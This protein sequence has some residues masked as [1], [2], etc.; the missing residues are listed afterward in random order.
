MCPLPSIR[1]KTDLTSLRSILSR[2]GPRAETR[3]ETPAQTRVAAPADPHHWPSGHGQL[4]PLLSL[5][6]LFVIWSNSFHS[7]AWLM[8]SMSAFDLVIARFAPVGVFSIVWCLLHEPKHNWQLLRQEPVRIV[9][10]GILIVPVYNFFLNWGQEE[11]PAGTASLL[12]AM[13]PLFTYLIALAIRQEHHR[14]RKTVGLLLSFSGVYFLL[15]SE[16]RAFG[17][18][19]GLRALSVLAA[20]FS[21]AIATVVARPV[22][23]RENP[24]RMTY[25]SLAVGSALFLAA[26]P[27][28]HS[29]RRAIGAFTMKD[30]FALT[31]LSLL[32]TIVGFG[33][34]YSTLRK[35]PAS[36]VAAFV[37]LNPPLTIAFGP[38]WG[39]GGPSGPLVLF[40]A[41]IL[42][43]IIL[44]TWKIPDRLTHGP[45]T[46][47]DSI[48]SSIGNRD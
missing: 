45:A 42:A 38:L 8:R 25:L 22:V 37:L 12:I 7:I 24:I 28:D 47:L 26:F 48:R 5:F 21:W 34:W 17:P 18:G 9:A 29:L 3:A 19:Y 39:S 36:S 11:V 35:L 20:P 14:I 40:G 23:V 4:V 1:I 41:W 2:K 15:V 46:V 31:H 10:L 6:L 13:N 30:W 27:F 44:S 16:G 33:I 43:G 32:C